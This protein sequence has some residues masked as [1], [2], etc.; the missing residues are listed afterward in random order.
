VSLEGVPHDL[1]AFLPYAV[2]AA[3]L[4]GVVDSIGGG[5]GIVTMPVM[6]Q[7]GLPMHAILGTNKGQAVVGATSS[8]YTFARRGLIARER[9]VPSLA[10]GFFGSLLGAYL[11]WLTNPAKLRAIILVLLLAAAAVMVAPK[12]KA[13]EQAVFV[14]ARTLAIASI[15][16]LYDGFFGPGTGT[17]LVAGFVA[18]EGDDLVRASAHAK[19]ANWASNVSAV[20]VFALKGVI[21]WP[22]ALPM[23]VA[24]AIGARIGATLAVT[25]GAAVIRPVAISVALALTAKTAWQLLQGG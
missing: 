23:A 11:A 21:L 15:V 16:G 4:A 2:P 9:I 6:L 19:V 20:I 17:L 13:R 3:F 8:L 12:P 10:G 7:T 18:F 5:G 24:N 14:P 22:L 25:K 1:T